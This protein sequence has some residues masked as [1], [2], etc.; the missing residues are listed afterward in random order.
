MEEGREGCGRERVRNEHMHG[1][2]EGKRGGRKRAE[3]GGSN[4]VRQRR[5][6]GREIGRE[7]HFKGGTLR[8]TLANIQCTAVSAQNNTQRGPCHCDFGITGILGICLGKDNGCIV[9]LE[10]EGGR[11]GGREGGR[12]GGSG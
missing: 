5:K 9:S 12:E 10:V 1:R 3:E 4:G 11:A 7:G 6:G 2:S 8:T